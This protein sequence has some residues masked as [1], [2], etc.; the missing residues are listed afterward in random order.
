[1]L[2]GLL[3]P[4]LVFVAVAATSAVGTVGALFVDHRGPARSRTADPGTVLR[5]IR[6][7]LLPD[8]SGN[9]LR[10]A[11]LRWLYLAVGIQGMAMTGVVALVPVYLTQDVGTTEETMGLLLGISPALQAIFMYPMGLLSDW[12][13]RKRV[14]VA[15]T[16]GSGVLFPALTATA[17]SVS[18]LGARVAVVVAAFV[19][20]AVAF[21]AMFSGTVAFV[22]DVTPADRSGEFMGLLW[23]AIGVGGVLGPL[24][25]GSIATV[26]GYEFSFLAGAALAVG[27]TIVVAVGV[28]A[29]PPV[30][31]PAN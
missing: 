15:G 13:G 5:E 19:V 4:W 14:I 21:S 22:G 20:L 24:L 1:M 3:A 8:V 11:G 17:T 28:D 9:V 2:V 12:L 16:A 18:G 23:T 7:R 29:D 10:E 31:T 27:A 26:T 25:L 30:V 6:A